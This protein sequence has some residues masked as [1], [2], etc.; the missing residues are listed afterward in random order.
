[1]NPPRIVAKLHNIRASKPIP[2]GMHH[3]VCGSEALNLAKRLSE[4]LANQQAIQGGSLGH[5]STQNKSP[6]EPRSRSFEQAQKTKGNLLAFENG[7]YRFHD[8]ATHRQPIFRNLKTTAE[9]IEFNLYL[10]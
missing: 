7:F 6:E 5:Q 1:M 2:I 4:E 3:T 10:R 9:A 8:A